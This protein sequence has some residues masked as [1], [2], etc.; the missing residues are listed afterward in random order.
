MSNTYTKRTNE[1]RNRMPWYEVEWIEF[2][3]EKRQAKDEETV[4]HEIE[5]EYDFSTLQKIE[6][7][8]VN[9][10]GPDEEEV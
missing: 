2:H 9:Y 6:F 8:S 7:Q 4:M 1:R 10:D 5:A 3:K